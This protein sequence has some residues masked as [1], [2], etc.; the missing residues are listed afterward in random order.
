MRWKWNTCWWQ[1]MFVIPD[2]NKLNTINHKFVTS[3]QFSCCYSFLFIY[4]SSNWLIKNE[5]VFPIKRKPRGSGAHFPRS[6][7]DKDSHQ[8][9]KMVC[10]GRI[11]LINKMVKWVPNYVKVS[12]PTISQKVQVSGAHFPRWH[13]DRDSAKAYSRSKSIPPR[14][15]EVKY[16]HWPITSE[17]WIVT[18]EQGR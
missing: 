2:S 13:T 18:I 12:T 9:R 16:L 17:K 4:M 7:A 14:V 10:R 3:Q 15:K 8:H 5:I 6:D 1:I 11:T